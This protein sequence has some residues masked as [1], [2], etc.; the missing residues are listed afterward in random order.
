MNDLLTDARD[1]VLEFTRQMND[2]E[3]KMYIFSRIEM[4]QFVSEE[5]KKLIENESKESLNQTYY[6][7]LEK[8]CTKKERKC[9]GHPYSFGKP[10]KYSGICE[11]A[12]VSVEQLKNHRIE[13]V[14]QSDFPHKRAYMFVLLRKN[15]KLKID[16][17]KVKFGETWRSALL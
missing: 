9:G 12:I 5:K 8:F 10:E 4:N 15:G 16:S 2:W 3:R 1:I 13:I 7:I 6:R 11:A 17:L 14:A